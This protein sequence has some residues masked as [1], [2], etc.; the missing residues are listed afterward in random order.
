MCNARPFHVPGNGSFHCRT[1]LDGNVVEFSQA[2]T[3]HRMLGDASQR[4]QPDFRALVVV[5]IH[6]ATI[7]K[8]SDQDRAR[9][10]ADDERKSDDQGDLLMRYAAS[11]AETQNAQCC[12]A[13]SGEC[14]AARH[15]SRP[16]TQRAGMKRNSLD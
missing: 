10:R 13:D 5:W 7:E 2:D 6:L 1:E 12:D 11:T 16:Q 4:A 14:R 8:L 15:L 9:Y 3:E